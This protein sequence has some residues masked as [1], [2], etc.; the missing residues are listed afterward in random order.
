MINRDALICLGIA[1]AILIATGAVMAQTTSLAITSVN[2]VDVVEGRI[3][4]NSTVTISGP[5][6][7]NVTRQGAPP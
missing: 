5:I 2:V 7:T 3:V 6:I 4:P 1:A